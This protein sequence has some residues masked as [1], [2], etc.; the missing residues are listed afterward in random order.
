MMKKSKKVL[1]LLL[2]LCMVAGMT[3][4][5]YA[6]ETVRELP[7]TEATD[8]EDVPESEESDESMSEPATDSAEADAET[9]GAEAPAEEEDESVSDQPEESVPEEADEPDGSG[10]EETDAGS[11]GTDESTDPDSGETP[12]MESPAEESPEA[13]TDET[14]EEPAAAEEEAEEEIQAVPAA[15][16]AEGLPENEPETASITV[17]T[18]PADG[19]T[20]GQPFAGG[21]GG[22]SNF[23]IPALVTLSDGTLVAAA[24]ARWDTTFDGWGL[25]TIVSYSEDGGQ[26]WNYTFANYFGDNGNQ[27]NSDSTAFID[28]ALAV[29][30]DDTVYMLVDLFPHGTYIRNVKAGTGFDDAGHLLLRTG[31]GS[32]YD[33]YVGDFENGIA[34]IYNTDGEQVSGYTVDEC[35]NIQSEDGEV[36]TNL[37]FSDSPY[38]VLSTSYLYLTKSTDGGKTWSA[39]QILNSQVKSS[40]DM[41]YGVGPGRGLTAT[42]ADGTERIIFPCYTYTTEGS[43]TSVIYSDDGGE[44]WTRSEDMAELSS[45]AALTEADGKIYMFTRYGGYYVS[46]DYGA[47]WSDRNSVNISY[48][49]TCQLSAIT[50]SEKIDGRT[51]ILLSAPTSGRTTGK[52]FVGLVQD[53]GSIEWKYTYE[54]NGSG[55]YAYSCLTELNDGSVGLLYEDDDASIT[56]TNIAASDIASGAVIGESCTVTDSETGISATGVGLNKIEVAKKS[57]STPYTG[58]SKSVTYA[59]TLNGGAYTGAADIKIPVDSEVFADCTEFIGSV[60]ESAGGSAETFGVKKQGN[61]FVGTVPHF[62]DVTISGK[63][64]EKTEEDITLYVGQYKT[65]I[66]ATGNYTVSSGNL[67]ENIAG[68]ALE[69]AELS[70]NGSVATDPVSMITSGNT[71]VLQNVESGIFLTNAAS[72]DRNHTNQ[73]ATTGTKTNIGT[74]ADHQWTITSAD[75]GYYV[76]DNNGKYLTIG[77]GTAAVTDAPT[78]LSLA[79][80][81]GDEP[82]TWT[83]GKS[84]YYLNNYGGG[85]S[86][87]AGWNEAN[88]GSC[89]NI[90]PVAG[91]KITFIGKSAGTTSVVVGTT[92]YNI[93]VKEMPEYVDTDTTPF[94]SGT[95]NNSGSK[96]TKLTTSVDTVYDLNVSVPGGGTWSAGDSG[97]AAVDQ[98]G[99]VIGVG[100]GTTT[101]T[102]TTDDGT[103]YTIPVVVLQSYGSSYVCDLYIAETTNT[104]VRY[105]I[106]LSTEFLDAAEGEAIYVGFRTP[107]CINFFGAEDEGYALTYMS[108]TKGGKNY[109]PLYKVS[110]LDSLTAYKEGAIYA[111]RSNGYFNKTAVDTM[112]WKAVNDGYHGTMG[113]TRDNSAS[114]FYS[115]LTFRSEKLPTVEKTIK[116]V[117]GTAYTEGMTAKAGDVIVYEVTV[118]QYATTEAIAYTNETLTDNLSGAVFTSNNSASIVPLLSDTTLKSDTANT[119]E[120]T[121]KIQ[122]SD[123]DKDII[124]TVDL[125][126]SYRGQYSSGTFGG[127]ASAEAKISAPTFAP[128]D[129]VIDFGLPVT[130]DYSGD[131]AH[132][133]YDLAS[134]SA[135]YGDVTVS[136]NKVTY[137][138]NTVLQGADTVTLTNTA[139]GTYTFKVY[140]ATTVYYE[141]GF[142]EYTGGWSGGTKGTEEQTLSEVGSRDHYGYDPKYAE[143]A[144]GS[145]N[146]TEA[147]STEAGNAAEFDFTGTGADLYFNCTADS[148]YVLVKVTDSTDATVV[149]KMLRINTKAA[150]GST[151]ATS[152]QNTGLYS[153]PVAS[154]SGLESGVY[155]VKMSHI[156]GAPGASAAKISLDGFRVYYDSESLTEV[157]S[158]DN[159]ANP[160]YLEL[161][162]TVL[163]GLAV[164]TSASQYADVIAKTVYEQVYAS[165]EGAPG[166]V[167]FDESTS[168]SSKDVQDLLDNGPKNELLLRKNQSLVFKAGENLVNAQIGMRNANGTVDYSVKINSTEKL[169]GSMTTST[170][171]FY[172]LGTLS[173]DDV[174]T[175]TN[176]GDGLLSITDLKFFGGGSEA[177]L[178]SLTEEDYGVALMS[179]GYAY[180]EPVDPAE[181]VEPTEP[182][183]VYADAVLNVSVTDYTGKEVAS[184][185]LTAN[186]V[187]G[188]KS[189]FNAA[190]ILDAVRAAL[191]DGYALADEQAAAD[192][193]VVNGETAEVNMQ[194]G[195]TAV[196]HITYYKLFRGTVGEATLTAVQTSS[197]KSRKFTPSE[198]KAAATDG[199][200]AISLIGTSVKYGSE[201]SITAITR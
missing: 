95:G 182:E 117:N 70:D 45:E 135:L 1:S 172:Q 5:A 62:S 162:N 118:T 123:L 34:G 10:Q 58:Y 128:K 177:A 163:A 180:S 159:E 28:P 39:P 154:I 149:V 64:V 175:V 161:R 166:A 56:Y 186:G 77:S 151:E 84:S 44:T 33:Y 96:V 184:V 176:T 106:N 178:A 9:P 19:Q 23:R 66:D 53:D 156:A 29:T 87:A 94:T 197:A 69:Y 119:Y 46:E 198:I 124:N 111:Q 131:G 11:D 86:Y 37:F 43:N 165:S 92:K 15:E 130:V 121:Y 98:N 171:M 12:A 125:N 133:R 24:D 152:G 52:I 181:P 36:D 63:A 85:E 167:V 143:E 194:A 113:F 146:R 72:T 38:Q 41:F 89:W 190:D 99:T 6:T 193:T 82:N 30:G 32:S 126:Y 140:P 107:F 50:Y 97:I 110:S 153:A 26:N 40:G 22:S 185:S 132:G 4:N 7:E 76:Q 174:V 160:N 75:G 105:S 108:S 102:Y 142:A 14:P 122:E 148:G 31:N 144:A 18:K 137:T 170:D 188:E 138:P 54:V 145:S 65:I 55:Y 20:G 21:T 16:A 196:L 104:T 67:N 100:E 59:I 157:Y 147:V 169:R 2:V 103:A 57:S 91:T 81:I 134:G 83:I 25:D 35:Y 136:G 116:T 68:I 127:S 27:S 3:I 150:D 49:T 187:S 79:Y 164:D 51:A 139:G 189:I 179:L 73:L 42:L 183:I 168:Y 109:Y 199:C 201:T 60:A 120:V 88:T 158:Q 129:I 115:S 101:V 8:T 155:T 48:T 78:V 141:E 200:S 112:L 195:K 192:Q 93:T 74:L 71:Y 61:D 114:D 191:P 90:Y 80:N 17:E 173:A 13:V 47:T